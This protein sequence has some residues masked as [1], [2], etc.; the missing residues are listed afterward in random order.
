MAGVFLGLIPGH[1]HA[2]GQSAPAPARYTVDRHYGFTIDQQ[3]WLNPAAHG[4]QHGYEDGFHRG[5]WAH[6]MFDHPP[7]IKKQ[8]DWK[9]ADRGYEPA[10]GER[11]EFR[12]GY[13]KGYE[14]GYEDA[15]SGHPFQAL[16]WLQRQNPRLVCL[17]GCR[18]ALAAV[19]P[20]PPR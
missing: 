10:M 4:Y 6:Q 7:A 8:S 5:E 11:E 3:L 14:Q 12:R 18:P 20:N 13:R 1:A 16:L 2:F 9:H 17:S 19:R 15:Y